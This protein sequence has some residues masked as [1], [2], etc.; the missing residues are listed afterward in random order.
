[1]LNSAHDLY[2]YMISFSLS[3]VLFSRFFH[4]E[5]RIGKLVT[6]EDPY[7]LHKGMGIL[8]ILSFLYRYGVIYNSTGTLGFTGTWFDWATLF[9]H[10][11]LA[12]SSKLFRVPK[13]RLANKPMVIYEEYRLHAMIFTFRCVSV[14][15]CA[16][17][18]PVEQRPVYAVALVV[19][20]HHL[21]ADYVTKIWGNGSTAVRTNA[22]NL[23]SFYKKV[24][25]F[26][27]FYQYMAIG[28]HILPSEHLADLAWNAIIAIASSAFMMTLYR[29]RIIRGMTHVVV[30]S[31]CLLLSMFH[32]MRLVGL[33]ATVLIAATFLLRINLPR[34]YSNKYVCWTLFFLSAHYCGLTS[35]TSAVATAS[36]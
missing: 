5:A 23:N 16:V 15:A 34:K 25:L 29:K 27:S 4:R 8:S 20:A 1:M 12:F 19:A 26:Y 9:V 35:T 33:V 28:S 2:K 3:S 32:I 18:W 13:K 36:A 21:L 24:A 10:M 6:K 11:T 14:Y 22:K 30:Y 7:H 17:L 31:A